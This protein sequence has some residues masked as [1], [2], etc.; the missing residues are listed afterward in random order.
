VWFALADGAELHNNDSS[1]DLH[2]FSGAARVPGLFVADLDAA[3][4]A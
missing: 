2:A 4:S 3:V 1:D